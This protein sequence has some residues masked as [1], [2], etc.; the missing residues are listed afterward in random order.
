MVY[1]LDEA[2][3]DQA[4]SLRWTLRGQKVVPLD[5][6]EKRWPDALTWFDWQLPHLAERAI[7]FVEVKGKLRVSIRDWHSTVQS[8]RWDAKV[9]AWIRASRSLPSAVGR[10][11]PRLF[12]HEIREVRARL[13]ED[14]RARGITPEVAVDDETADGQP[15]VKMVA[16][17]NVFVSADQQ[18]IVARYLSEQVSEQG[19]RLPDVT[20]SVTLPG[21]MHVVTF[22]GEVDV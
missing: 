18:R 3:D 5:E 20:F 13:A 6:I 2:S 15:C 21:A 10:L 22:S 1:M 19:R 11:P 14:L 7:R 4:E 16:T 9:G 17:G 8:P 12:E